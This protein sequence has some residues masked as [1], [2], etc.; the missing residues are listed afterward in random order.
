MSKRSLMEENIDNNIKR[1]KKVKDDN[2][3]IQNDDELSRGESGRD[4]IIPDPTPKS[5]KKSEEYLSYKRKLQKAQPSEAYLVYSDS[6]GVIN[7][8]VAIIHPGDLC[9][10]S[11]TCKYFNF[12]LQRWE[13]VR[14]INFRL[15][16]RPH[17]NE[18]IVKCAN[19]DNASA[20]AVVVMYYFHYGYH[21]YAAKM[22]QRYFQAMEKWYNRS[23]V[24]SIFADP[25]GIIYL[26]AYSSDDDSG[27]ESDCKSDC[28]SDFKSSDIISDRRYFGGDYHVMAYIHNSDCYHLRLNLHM[29]NHDMVLMRK[30]LSSNELAHIIRKLNLEQLHKDSGEDINDC[31]I[32]DN[33][34]TIA[35]YGCNSTRRMELSEF[36]VATYDNNCMFNNIR[37]AADANE[38]SL[39]LPMIRMRNNCNITDSEIDG[40]DTESDSEDT[41]IDN[42]ID[43]NNY[44]VDNVII[45]DIENDGE[46]DDDIEN[47]DENDGELER[48]LTPEIIFIKSI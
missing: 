40:D 17:I 8:I 24:D 16:S 48:Y 35:T 12:D 32:I 15:Y 18:F 39:R 21:K 45:D 4:D 37:V 5:L 11:R 10:L 19:N 7:N 9:S 25:T 2:E 42:E 29:D 1:P 33:V 3:P 23:H 14:N 34:M 38:Y 20:L 41:E 46:N 44:G 6:I 26:N 13:I 43:N 30:N 22:L 28:K 36:A 47:D 31:F 27:S